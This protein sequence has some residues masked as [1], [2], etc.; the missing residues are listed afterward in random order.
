MDSDRGDDCAIGPTGMSPSQGTRYETKI[1]YASD[2]PLNKGRTSVFS[3]PSACVNG[4]PNAYMAVSH[5]TSG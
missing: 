4:C 2:L 5:T 1:T 3:R